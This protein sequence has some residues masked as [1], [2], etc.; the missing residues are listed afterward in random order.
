[1]SKPRHVEVLLVADKSMTDFHDASLETYLLT[2]MNMVCTNEFLIGSTS[3]FYLVPEADIFV[4]SYKYHEKN[5]MKHYNIID[6]F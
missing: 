5:I 6:F 3:V 2:I 1:M 4:N